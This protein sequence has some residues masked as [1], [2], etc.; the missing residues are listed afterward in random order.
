MNRIYQGKVAKVEIADGN[1]EWKSFAADCA[2]IDNRSSVIGN[3][4]KARG[5]TNNSLRTQ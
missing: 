1:G 2:P 5:S 3:S 4:P